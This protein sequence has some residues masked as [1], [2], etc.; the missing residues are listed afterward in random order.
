MIMVSAILM[1]IRITECI[2][3]KAPQYSSYSILNETYNSNLVF[4]FSFIPLCKFLLSRSSSYLEIWK[5]LK[6]DVISEFCWMFHHNELKK[7]KILES[8]KVFINLAYN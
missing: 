7:L 4:P 6:P 8:D 3:Q 1:E 5:N 2:A